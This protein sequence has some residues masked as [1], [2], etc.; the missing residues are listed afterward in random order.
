MIITSNTV[1]APFSPLLSFRIIIRKLA[2]FTICSITCLL[3]SFLCFPISFMFQSDFF[4]FYFWFFY[5]G[6]TGLQQ[7]VTFRHRTL[8]V[9]VWVYNI[10]LITKSF[11]S[12]CDYVT[13]LLCP[14]W[15]PSYGLPHSVLILSPAGLSCYY[16][17]YCFLTFDYKMFSSQICFL[18]NMPSL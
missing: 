16:L 1:S 13:D 14:F 12:L 7:Y 18:S 10:A 3:Q 9:S 17:T 8:W 6:N 2:L 4:H 11:V 15:I 5:L